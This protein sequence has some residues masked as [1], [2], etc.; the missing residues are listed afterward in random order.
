MVTLNLKKSLFQR[1]LKGISAIS[2]STIITV[3]N[4]EMYAISASEDNALYLYS[5]I[6]VDVLETFKM[7]V[8]SVSKLEKAIK[9]IG[10]EDI[11]LT[12]NRNRLE[13]KN[14]GLKFVYHLMDEGVLPASKIS[15][16][17]INSFNFDSGFEIPTKFVKNLLKQTALTVTD[18]VYIYTEDG[19]LYW[20]LGDDTKPNSDSVTIRSIETDVEIAPFIMKTKNLGLVSDFAENLDFRLSSERVGTIIIDMDE[21]RIQYILA[22]LTQ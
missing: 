7:N 17:K 4:G 8:P 10:C 14:D 6:K 1:F 15:I 2:D 9:L 21:L 3:E 22:R 11:I 20:K 19:Y 5:K 18:K 12:F 16:A 13:Y